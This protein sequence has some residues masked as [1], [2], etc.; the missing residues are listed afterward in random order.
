MTDDRFAVNHA[1]ADGQA[2]DGRD[3][4]P[5]TVGQVIAIP[6]KKPNAAI[7]PTRQD[8]DLVNPAEPGR[9]FFRRSRQA[10]F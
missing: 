10:R 3:D 5:E 4:L 9:R 8:L 7:I 1:R 6:G 2:L